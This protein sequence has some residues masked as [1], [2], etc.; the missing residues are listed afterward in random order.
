MCG[1][2]NTHLGFFGLIVEACCNFGELRWE[3]DGLLNP[4]KEP[5][6]RS[7]EVALSVGE[8]AKAVG[9]PPPHLQK[10]RV[11]V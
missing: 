3:Q 8:E 2:N 6:G 10:Y 11:L 5:A 7:E 9:T 1:R 4:R